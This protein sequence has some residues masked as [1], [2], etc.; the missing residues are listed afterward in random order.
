MTTALAVLPTPN[1]LAQLDKA[2]QM[3]AESRTLP[4]VKKIRNM[5]EAARVYAKAASL[6]REAQK[7][8][9]EIGLLAARK[10]GTI[11]TQLEKTP[12]QSAAKVSGDSEYRKT[13][14]ETGTSERTAQRW[15]ELAIIPD[16]TVDA[17]VQDSRINSDVD[18]TTAG[19]IK[20]AKQAAPKCKP[21]TEP[22]VAEITVAQMTAKL[23]QMRGEFSELNA[24]T[25]RVRA[26]D[27]DATAQAEVRTLVTCLNQIAHDA[28]ARTMIRDMSG[29][30]RIVRPYSH[31][32]IVAAR[33]QQ[34]VEAVNAPPAYLSDVER[35]AWIA[36]HQKY[37]TLSVQSAGFQTCVRDTILKWSR[38]FVLEQQ[39][40]LAAANKKG[41][42]NVAVNKVL[43]A[44]AKISNP[45]MNK[46]VDDKGNERLW[47]G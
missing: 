2:R 35:D 28:D 23:T 47:L 37:P 39:P 20:R 41:E 19:L 13:L 46:R 9:A 18:I 3:L 33:R 8:A 6:G 7:F 29:S 43:N 12:K 42:L 10:A 24:I 30:M 45:N 22:E 26:A 11:L 32:E 15:Q 44:W 36:V 25:K 5:A 17:Y 27:L 21:I 34:T 1:A 14:Q 38:E 4:E 40:E 16:A 31:A